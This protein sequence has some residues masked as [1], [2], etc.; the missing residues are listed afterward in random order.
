MLEIVDGITRGNLARITTFREERLTRDAQRLFGDLM[1]PVDGTS[2]KVPTGPERHS[3]Q[4]AVRERVELERVELVLRQERREE[5]E[6]AREGL[7]EMM[8][9]IGPRCREPYLDG[10]RRRRLLSNVAM[11]FSRVGDELKAI[12]ISKF[13][14]K[15]A[16]APDAPAEIVAFARENSAGERVR[17]RLVLQLHNNAVRRTRLAFL[18]SLGGDV[19]AADELLALAHQE[20]SAALQLRGDS[21]RTQTVQ[22]RLLSRTAL[23]SIELEQAVLVDD[24]AKRTPALEDVRDRLTSIVAESYELSAVR[25]RTRLLRVAELGMVFVEQALIAE[26][27]G[28]AAF[29]KSLGWAGRA[30]LKPHLDGFVTDADE[31]PA[32]AVRYGHACRLS[33]DKQQAMTIWQRSRDR[34]ALYRGDDHSAAVAVDELLDELRPASAG[35]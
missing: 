11:C 16:G 14:I 19:D 17:S 35:A 15:D 4:E 8:S 22:A 34:L 13:L 31:A 12:E 6:R 1:A 10:E 26:A 25:P 5:I 23:A 3:P 20:A 27:A 33:G 21:D 7:H 32:K 24:L 29:A 28:D 2:G 9:R 18:A 30:A